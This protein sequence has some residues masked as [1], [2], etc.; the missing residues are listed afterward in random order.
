MSSGGEAAHQAPVNNSI[1]MVRQM[2]PVKLRGSQK[3]KQRTT[4]DMDRVREENR[5]SRN[6]SS[7]R[8]SF[9]HV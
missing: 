2:T 3:T 4:G 7:N 9:I 1:P 8:D 5:V 6:Y